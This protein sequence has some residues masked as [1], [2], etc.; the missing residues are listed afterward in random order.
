MPPST[1]TTSEAWHDY[2]FVKILKNIYDLYLYS[3]G[4]SWELFHLPMLEASKSCST[5]ST[6]STRPKLQFGAER[7]TSFY[8]NSLLCASVSIVFVNVDGGVYESCWLQFLRSKEN[9]LKVSFVHLENCGHRH[10]EFLPQSRWSV[11]IFYHFSLVI[12]FS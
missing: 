5:T 7:H 9:A 4:I 6:M 2:D 1:K 12:Q 8:E 10:C 3:R 11:P